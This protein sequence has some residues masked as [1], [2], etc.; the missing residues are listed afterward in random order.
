[1]SE[2]KDKDYGISLAVL[3]VKVRALEVMI[4]ELK[5]AL[6]EYTTRTEFLPVKIIVYGFIAL[7]LT[8]LLNIMISQYMIID[9]APLAKYNTESRNVE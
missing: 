4:D 3:I 7:I 9:K 8:G 2:D 5:K 1:M 6:K